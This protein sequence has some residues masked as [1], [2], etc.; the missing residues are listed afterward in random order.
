[1]SAA[2]WCDIGKHSFSASDEN[3]QQMIVT[4]K[5]PNQWGG[6]QPHSIQQDIC[7]DCL[8]KAGLLDEDPKEIPPTKVDAG[9]E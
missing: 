5:V 4:K 8:R 9:G 2:L 7:S 3:A 6:T 1:M